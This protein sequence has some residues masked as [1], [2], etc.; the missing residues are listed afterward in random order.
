M[1][2]ILEEDEGRVG[3]GSGQGG[4]DE[5][6]NCRWNIRNVLCAEK[7]V[8]IRWERLFGDIRDGIA[9]CG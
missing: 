1:E 3:V 4:C 2:A 8:V 5:I 9:D 6:D 7:D